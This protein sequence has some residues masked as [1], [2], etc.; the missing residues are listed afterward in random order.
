MKDLDSGLEKTMLSQ[1]VTIYRGVTS[2][3]FGID[4]SNYDT[5]FEGDRTRL[6][7]DLQQFV[8]KSFTEKGYMSTSIR[9]D[10]AETFALNSASKG[11]IVMVVNAKKGTKGA[12]NLSGKG[13][14]G[15]EAEVLFGRNKTYKVTSVREI[16]FNVYA[17]VDLK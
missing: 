13:Y 10:I 4:G 7:G 3:I 1:D 8:G 11:G 2:D 15:H 14:N 5:R 16:G 12:I 6:I 9:E 17:F